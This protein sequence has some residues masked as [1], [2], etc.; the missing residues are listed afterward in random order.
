MQE[1]INFKSNVTNTM[2]RMVL[3]ATTK[4]LTTCFKPLA[5]LMARNGRSTLRIRSTLSTDNIWVLSDLE[6]P[7]DINGLKLIFY[8]KQIFSNI[9]KFKFY[10][11]IGKKIEM[12]DMMTTNMSSTLKALRQNAPLCRNTPYA[13][14]LR[15]SSIVKMV[16]KK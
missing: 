6:P 12:S 2:F 11:T 16:V 3:R 10:M 9:F 8:S 1:N 5:L 7:S 13:I 4:Q 14:S 15:R